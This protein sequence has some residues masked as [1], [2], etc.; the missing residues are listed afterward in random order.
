MEISFPRVQGRNR[1]ARKIPLAKRGG[2]GGGQGENKDGEE[3]EHPDKAGRG[4]RGGMVP[5]KLG[6]K[7]RK[8]GRQH[9]ISGSACRYSKICWF[10]GLQGCRRP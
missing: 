5:S 7:G 3:G 9:V 2:G 6:K 4:W 8:A 1:V 10:C